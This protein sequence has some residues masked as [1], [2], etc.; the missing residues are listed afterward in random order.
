MGETRAQVE[1]A[2]HLEHYGRGPCRGLTNQGILWWQSA[3]Y[4]MQLARRVRR[5]EVPHGRYRFSWR[6]MVE[7]AKVETRHA[8]DADRAVRD[9]RASLTDPRD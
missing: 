7:R 3:R 2:E 6:Q 9:R 4:S 1:A 5:G 8:R